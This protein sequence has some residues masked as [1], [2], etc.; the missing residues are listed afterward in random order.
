MAQT[1][2]VKVVATFSILAD[3][4]KQVGGGR[5]E[6]S[7]LV[8]PNGD[9]H[10]YQASP[11]DGRKI[12][13]A[14]VVIRN[15]LGLEGW[16]ERFIAAT[17]AKPRIVVVG[18]HVKAFAEG[19]GKFDPHAWQDVANVKA[20]VMDIR[21]GLIAADPAGKASYEAN[22]ASY[23]EKLTALD[24]DV[25]AAIASIPAG[26]RRIITT[27]DAFGYFGRAYGLT[28]LAPKG[29]STD[30]EPTAKDVAAIIRQIRT[31]KV[32]AV[33]LEN[34]SDPRLI[35]RIAKETGAKMGGTLYSDAL[36]EPSG[37]AGTYIDMMRNNIREFTA[38]LRP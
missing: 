35:Q 13:E 37:P 4:A 30:A 21:D 15:G 5:I 36:S 16:F 23:L 28:F 19:K 1:A 24:A 7:S 3:L 20:Y 8:G 27:H 2:P 11:A 32:P 31:E 14:S 34:V 25:R 38:A 6:V 33:F 22:A 18:E 17:G 12:A 10:V 29:V 9:A 26:R